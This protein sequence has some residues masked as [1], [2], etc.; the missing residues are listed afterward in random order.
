MG[1]RTGKAI[2]YIGA[3]PGAIEGQTPQSIVSQG[4]PST[5]QANNAQVSQGTPNQG[6][7]TVQQG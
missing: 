6:S 2:N 3:A 7:Q 1:G 4:N 5:S